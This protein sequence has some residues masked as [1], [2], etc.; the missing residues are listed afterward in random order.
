MSFSFRSFGEDRLIYTWNCDYMC[1]IWIV[2]TSSFCFLI[3]YIMFKNAYG[4]V[5]LFLFIIHSLNLFE[6]LYLHL[7][8]HNK[9]QSIHYKYLR[10]YKMGSGFKSSKVY[11][12]KAQQKPKTI[13]TTS[14]CRLQLNT[15]RMRTEVCRFCALTV[16]YSE[17]RTF[18]FVAWIHLRTFF[19]EN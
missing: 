4:T 11:S 7:H 19:L 13:V 15:R 8:V 17:H 18:W 10:I 6:C 2:F 14:I 16:N 1:F 12:S 5:C 3:M 9:G